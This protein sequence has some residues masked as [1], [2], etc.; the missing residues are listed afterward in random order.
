MSKSLDVDDSLSKLANKAKRK[1][2]KQGDEDD[3]FKKNMAENYIF[4][5]SDRAEE[6]KKLQ[7]KIVQILKNNPDCLNPIGKLIDHNIYDNLNESQKQNYVL[8]LSSIYREVCET[9]M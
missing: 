9:L 4:I 8:K 7:K 6:K 5:K 2:N 1:L 3:C